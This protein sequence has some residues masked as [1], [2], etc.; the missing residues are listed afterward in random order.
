MVKMDERTLTRFHHLN[1]EQ[2]RDLAHRSH[3]GGHARELVSLLS[4]ARELSLE[5]QLASASA[6]EKGTGL[7]CS[8]SATVKCLKFCFNKPT[9]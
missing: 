7:I 9:R 2:A 6:N 4:P 8:R 3:R 1:K 5:T